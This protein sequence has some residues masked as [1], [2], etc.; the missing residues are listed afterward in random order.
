MSPRDGAVVEGGE[1]EEG[2]G[3][4]AEFDLVAQG[5]GVIKGWGCRVRC[6]SVW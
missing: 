5:A 2:C 3:G 1:A 4:A 6:G